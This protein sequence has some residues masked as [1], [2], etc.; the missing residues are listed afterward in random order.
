MDDARRLRRKRE[1]GLTLLGQIHGLVRAFDQ[2]IHGRAVFRVN[3]YSYTCRDAQLHRPSAHGEV[4]GCLNRPDELFR[5]ERDCGFIPDFQCQVQ[6][7]V[8]AMA[9][10]GVV[11]ARSALEPARNGHQDLVACVMSLRIVDSLEI[12]QVHEHDRQMST[13]PLGLRDSMF[14]TDIEKR[15]V[16]KTRQC[17]M[18]CGRASCFF[19]F[20]RCRI[21][22]L[23]HFPVPG[24]LPQFAIHG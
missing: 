21:L 8:P 11:A 12:V 23:E 6:K 9:T 4:A 18:E 15:A 22:M 16:R 13:M 3:R 10:D 1:P 20:D 7:L 17:V 19:L 5:N 14:K 2:P 24:F